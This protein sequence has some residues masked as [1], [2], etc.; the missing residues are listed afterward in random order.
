MMKS[1]TICF[2]IGFRV[3]LF[4]FQIVFLIKIALNSLKIIIAHSLLISIKMF[5]SEFKD[6]LFKFH[7]AF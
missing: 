5:K 4:N 2:D 1:S 3:F 7:I 6:F